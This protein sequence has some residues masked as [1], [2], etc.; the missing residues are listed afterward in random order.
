[1][2][3]TGT[4]TTER[5]EKKQAVV[6]RAVAVFIVIVV[7]FIVAVVSVFV[8]IVVAVVVGVYVPVTAV[9]DLD[10]RGLHGPNAFALRVSL[11]VFRYQ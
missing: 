7:V 5:W 10:Y 11:K 8:V 1:M 4:P 6:V 3:N 2:W 9:T